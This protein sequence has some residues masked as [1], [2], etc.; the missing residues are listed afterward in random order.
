MLAER[1][2]NEE[3]GTKLMS[4][5]EFKPYPTVDERSVWQRLPESLRSAQVALGEQHLGCE[6]P[7]LPAT[8]FMEFERRGDRKGY[9]RLSFGRRNAL[10]DLVVAE[11]IEDKGRF[12]DCI[13]DGIWAICEESFWGVPAHNH[14]HGTREPL[15]DTSRPAIDL[16]AAET[17]GLLAWTHYLLKSR[18]D[19]ISKLICERIEREVAQRITHPYLER[20]DFWWMG[21]DGTRRVN[22][23]NPWCNSNCLTVLFLLEED[24]ERRRAGVAKSLRSLDSFLAVYS[25]DGGCDEGTSYWSRAG[26]S[27][28]DCLELLCAASNGWI[29]VYREPLIGEIGRFMVRAYISGD[30]F[31][32]F[33]DG[34][35]KLPVYTGAG[36]G[37][38]PALIYAYGRRIGDVS[39]QALGTARHHQNRERALDVQGSLL[40]RLPAIF[41]FANLEREESQPPFLPDVWLPHTQV[42]A[43]RERA[44][45]D[46]GLYVAAKGG[47]NAESHNHNDV[48]NF[49]VYADGLPVLV[50][51]GVGT[52][53]KQTFSSGRYDLWT[54]Q[55]AYH[56]LPTIGGV[57]QRAGAEYRAGR[58]EYRVDDEGAKL[59]LDLAPAYPVEAGVNL[60]ERSVLLR[61]GG[62]PY[63]EVVDTFELS[64]P[65]DVVM[66]L[67]TP[68]EP[69]VTCA[70]GIALDLDPSVRLAYDGSVLNAT[71]ERLEMEDDRLRNV[72][73][74]SLFRLQLRAKE[75]VAKGTWWIRLTRGSR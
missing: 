59:T 34:A 57:Q 64:G 41:E 53:T 3:L 15:P 29:D 47:H 23:W 12:L 37:F 46:R 67:M 19:G 14:L 17:A 18:L 21:L 32:N 74:A 7:P 1:F 44:Q 26:G 63:V 69:R 45:T 68:G 31:I 60:W 38:S 54:M 39:L 16:F 40:R 52:Y 75:R 73:G 55:S 5:E 27:L 4:R 72:W 65:K 62:D 30:Y 8:R 58:V 22:N 10:A 33:A 48:G 13:V 42:M 35:G 6:W 43:A 20:D 49:I 66:S 24:D 36:S 25:P 56:N 61:R 2:A 11:C 28:F 71:V 9:E 51:A 70:G 50:D